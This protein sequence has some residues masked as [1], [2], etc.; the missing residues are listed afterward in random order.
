[1]LLPVGRGHD[2]SVTLSTSVKDQSPKKKH[3][4]RRS[5]S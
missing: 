1:V 2:V 5:L 4:K 3:L